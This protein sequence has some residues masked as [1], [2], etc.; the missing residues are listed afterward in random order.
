M[1]TSPKIDISA[2]VAVSVK[3][4]NWTGLN[5]LQLAYA[6]RLAGEAIPR[7]ATAAANED[8]HLW[9]DENDLFGGI[10]LFDQYVTEFV[11]LVEAQVE[12]GK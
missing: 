4:P 6:G 1:K 10:G 5:A 9:Y 2:L 7:W 11:A 3:R 12:A 8:T